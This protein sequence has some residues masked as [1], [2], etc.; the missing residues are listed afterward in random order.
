MTWPEVE[1]RLRKVDMALLPVGAIEQHGPHLT[2]DIDA[3]D[4]DYLVRR[5]AAACSDPKPFVLPLVPY[6]VSYHHEEFPGTVSLTNHTLAQ[7]IYEIG[8]SV[9][10][11]GI[12]KLI[13]V[14]GHGDNQPTLNYAAQMINR[15][16]HIFCCVDSGETSDVDIDELA[17]TPNDV[18]AGE[19]ETSTT[20][21]VRPHLVDMSKAK[22][23]VPRFS[24]DYL[25]FS[26][27]R[28]VEWYARTRKISREGVLGDPTKATAEKGE[29]IWR[30]MVRNLVELVEHI[31]RMSLDEIY[32][33]RY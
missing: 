21:A 31:K 32:E 9:A 23:F 18:H 17:D 10:R 11:N 4:A 24:T 22:P 2:L 29:E 26:G 15:D 20:L 27:S 33:R 7:L 5:V 3:F 25:D 28:A 16:L 13:I 19:I 8:V 6:G 30:I 12:K 14:N 1:A